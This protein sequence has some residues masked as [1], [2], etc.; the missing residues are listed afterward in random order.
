MPDS[1]RDLLEGIARALREDVAPHVVDR[2]AEM[3]CKAAAEL[4]A[5]LAAELDWAPE[6][7][8]RRRAWEREL[9]AALRAAGWSGGDDLAA[10]LRWLASCPPAASAP[11]DA[12]LR[13][14]LER[15]VSAL[16]RGMFS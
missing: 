11:V 14:D 9:L 3:Q 12:L 7:L 8:A 5:N 2:F 10:A 1:A 13:E 16:R 6:P 15:Q 4:L